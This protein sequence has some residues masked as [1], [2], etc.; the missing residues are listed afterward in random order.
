MRARLVPYFE[1]T[2]H[3]KLIYFQK[4]MLWLVV[5][6]MQQFQETQKPGS[7]SQTFFEKPGNMQNRLIPYVSALR[8]FIDMRYLMY[9]LT[10]NVVLRQP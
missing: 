6:M 10:L 3:T 2:V 8:L 1:A 5:Y 7:F 4:H 9:T